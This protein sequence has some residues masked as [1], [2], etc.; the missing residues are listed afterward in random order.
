MTED[1]G[2][3]WTK[4]NKFYENLL[5]NF[6]SI[7][8]EGDMKFDKHNLD[9]WRQLPFLMHATFSGVEEVIEE[10][11]GFGS[12]ALSWKPFVAELQDQ[13]LPIYQEHEL[14]FDRFHKV[15]GQMHICRAVIFGEIMGRHYDGFG[16]PVDF[17]GVRIAIALHDSGREDGGRDR[18][19]KQSAEKCF[20]YLNKQPAYSTNPDSDRIASG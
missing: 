9:H 1:G 10:S 18:W 12:P 13:I 8:I 14:T 16:I 2:I 6:T 5:D 20:N 3:T 4:P 11:D 19:E 17:Y 15:H 7:E